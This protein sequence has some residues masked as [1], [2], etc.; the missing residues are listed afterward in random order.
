MQLIERLSEFRT[1][2]GVPRAELEWLEAHGELRVYEA[3]EVIMAK[4]QTVRELVAVLDGRIRRPLHS[5]H[6][7]HP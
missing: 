6:R 5:W 2:A 1:L 7:T 3:G 4:G